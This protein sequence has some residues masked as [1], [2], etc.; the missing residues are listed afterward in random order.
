MGY[1]ISIGNDLYYGKTAAEA[2]RKAAAALAQAK[3]AGYVEKL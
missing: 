2:N 3:E 1:Y